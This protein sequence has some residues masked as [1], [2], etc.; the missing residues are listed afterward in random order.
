M[1]VDLKE[2]RWIDIYVNEEKDIVIFPQSETTEPQELAD[3]TMLNE[4]W[5]CTAYYPIEIK[6]PYTKEEVA[7]KIK[8]GIE[9]WNKT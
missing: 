3:G 6:H 2:F 4:P 9:Q 7:E 5:L 8:Y 1:K